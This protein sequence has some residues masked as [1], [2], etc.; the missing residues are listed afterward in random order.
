VQDA[1]NFGMDADRH[2][3]IMSHVEAQFAPQWAALRDKHNEELRSAQFRARQTHN[4]AAILPAE[5]ACY[6]GHVKA[7]ILARA[8]C[9][10]EAYTAF[11]E[12]AGHEAEAELASFFV[13][14]LGARKASF[15]GEVAL[16]EMRTRT[17]SR[18]LVGLLRGFEREANPALL[19]GRAI[20]DRQ[21]VEM[22]NKSKTS[23]LATKYVVD[24]CV[25]NWLADGVL[26]RDQL[27]SD[28]GFA[29]THIQV[30]EINET[31]HQERRARLLL[32]QASLRCELLPTQSF[33]LDVSRLDHA[34]LGDGQLFGS[35]RAELDTLNRN[36]KSNTR[37]ALIAEAAIANGYTLLTADRDLRLVT[38]KHSGKVIFF[39]PRNQ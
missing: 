30:D 34:K 31:K 24:T 22:E 26:T 16:R 28:G 10:A 5:A 12:P 14:V 3:E 1:A 13:T 18:Q 7:L 11:N 20:L 2:K 15:Q 8:K 35:I 39:A 25:F 17:A 32:V 36:K 21:R 38:E 9:I 23:G 37:D 19:E 4:T 29:I 27:P 6:I 33:V